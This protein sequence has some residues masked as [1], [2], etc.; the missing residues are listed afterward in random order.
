MRNTVDQGDMAPSDDTIYQ[1]GVTV[2]LAVVATVFAGLKWGIS[3]L[4][5]GQLQRIEKLE[6]RVDSFDDKIAEHA[7]SIAACQTSNSQIIAAISRQE[8]RLD[9]IYNLLLKMPKRE[10]D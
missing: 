7:Q 2:V 4:I 3:N 9:A 1:V 6:G 8:Q 10:D 5:N